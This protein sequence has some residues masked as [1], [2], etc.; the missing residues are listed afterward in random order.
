MLPNDETSDLRALGFNIFR[1]DSIVAHLG[2]REDQDLPGITRIRQ[3]F[4]I[5]GQ[6]RIENDFPDP[7][8][9]LVGTK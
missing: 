5:A 8:I 7:T 9:V 6:G 3:G 4:L 2:S 1:A